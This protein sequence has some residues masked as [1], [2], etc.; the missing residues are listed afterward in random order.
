M[1][2]QTKPQSKRAKYL[3]LVATE[4]DKQLFVSEAKKTG[5]SL[6]SFLRAA[7]FEKIHRGS[8]PQFGE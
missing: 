7:A 8:R 2:E 1:K 4:D 5:L 6:S 3:H